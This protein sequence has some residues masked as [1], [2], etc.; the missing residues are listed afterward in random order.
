MAPLVLLKVNGRC[1]PAGAN[2]VCITDQLVANALAACLAV[3]GSWFLVV[4]C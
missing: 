4:G 1:L 2:A 3:A